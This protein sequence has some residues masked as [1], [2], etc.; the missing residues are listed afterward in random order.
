[1]SRRQDFLDTLSFSV[2]VKIV[3]INEGT[4]SESELVEVVGFA[5]VKTFRNRGLMNGARFPC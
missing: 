4:F 1:M 5:S 2:W 3:Q